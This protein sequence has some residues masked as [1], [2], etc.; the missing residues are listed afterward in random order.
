MS[1][2]VRIDV[3]AD[4]IKDLPRGEMKDALADDLKFAQ[5][6]NGTVDPALRGIKRLVISGI[7]RELLTHE[8]IADAIKVHIQDC[9]LA[10]IPTGKSGTVMAWAEVLKPY[11]W[12]VAIIC[13][14]PFAGDIVAKVIAVFK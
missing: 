4:A 11:R 12:P 3:L 14:S 8:R 13:F 10:K 7:R 5:D 6:I 9:P 2:D 1:Y